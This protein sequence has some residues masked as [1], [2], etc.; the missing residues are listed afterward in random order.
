M[1]N[2]RIRSAAKAFAVH[3]G[4]SALLAALI[5]AW[6]FWVWF[7]YPF[8]ELLGG[9]RLFFI[10]L[11]VDVICGPLLTAIL[12]NPEKSR[13]ELTLDLSIVVL[14]QL[15]ALG[16]GLH[17]L[18]LARPVALVYEVDRFVAVTRVQVAP[19]YWEEAAPPYRHLPFYSRPRVVGIRAPKDAAEA[20]KNF[21]LSL[22]G[23]EPS[24]R[25]NWWQPYELSRLQVVERMKKLIDLR[26][27][28]PIAA[29][30]AIDAAASKTGRSISELHYLPLTSQKVLDGWIVLLDGQAH[31]V[32]YAPVDGF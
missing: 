10:L 21:D 24:V 6:I 8:H 23:I 27:Q 26:S 4:I 13:R 32:G 9:T 2:R 7:P 3:L 14:I 12:F 17:S 22:S 20:S 31:I 18:S 16:Y 28:R 15:A 30:T 1:K 19:A 29:Q 5:G 25:P 11:G